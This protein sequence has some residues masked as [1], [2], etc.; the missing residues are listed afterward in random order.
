[1]ACL[2]TRSP[3]RH[4][5]WEWK[6]SNQC[7]VLPDPKPAAQTIVPKPNVRNWNWCKSIQLSRKKFSLAL[8]L[9]FFELS[10]CIGLPAAY[11]VHFPSWRVSSQGWL[12]I[13][14]PPCDQ[15]TIAY[16]CSRFSERAQDFDFDRYFYNF[17]SYTSIHTFG[18]PTVSSI[19]DAP[20]T[21]CEPAFSSQTH[22]RWTQ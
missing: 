4:A 8:S 14:I 12:D 9:L 3:L 16:P 19:Q 10:S 15:T 2:H 11:R 7:R 17:A 6:K 5:H 13:T 18:D 20:I 21:H 22:L 1:M